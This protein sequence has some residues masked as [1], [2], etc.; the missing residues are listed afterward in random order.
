MAQKNIMSNLLK[1]KFILGFM[2]V[3]F[4]LVGVAFTATSAKAECSLGSTTLKYGQRSEAVKCLQASLNVSPATG[5]FGKLTLAAVKAFQTNK[6]LTADGL[7]GR[8]TKAV[9]TTGTTPTPVTGYEPAGCTSASGFSPVTGGACHAVGTT[10]TPVSGPLTV[11]LAS[12]NPAAGTIVA[13]QATA[14]LAHFTFSGTGTLSAITL[15]RGGI[16]DQNTLSNLYL[17]DGMARL[18]DGYSFNNSGDLTVSGLNLAIA[19]TKTLS[20]RADVLSGT[21]SYSVS[22]AL[23]SYTVTGGTANAVSL[24]GNEMY[25]ASAPSNLGSAVFTTT[26][27]VSGTPQVNPGTVGYTVWST[28]MQINNRALL[29]KGANF[30]VIGSA[31]SDALANVKLYQ[32]GIA[33]GGTA[34][35]TT[36]NGSTYLSFDMSA[37]PVTLATGGHTFDVRADIV[38]GSARTVQVSLQQVSDLML[39]D[40]QVGINVAAGVSG[41]S[42]SN[43]TTAA[44]IDIKQG[45][46]STAV[47]PTFQSLTTL[48]GGATNVTI[49]KFK[50]HGYGEDVKINSLSITPNIG[51][52]SV[53]APTENGLQNVTVY[54][55]GSQVGSQTANWASTTG[56]AGS[57]IT[58][59]PG[60]QM[61]VPAGVDSYLEV[62][63]DIRT[64]GGVN[65]TSGSVSATLDAVTGGGEGMISH[66]SVDIA[67]VTGTTLTVQ[68]GLLAIASN[69]GFA[70]S[71]VVSPNTANTKIA[72]F[73]LQN[74][75]SSESIRV[76]NLQV[77]LALTTAGSTNYSN[78]RT[79][80]TSGSGAT[81]VNPAT[82]SAPG[83]STN[84]FQVDFTIAP[85]T[86]KTI[87]VLTDIGST[88]GDATVITKLYVTALGS[89]SNVTLCSPTMTGG[90][91]NGCNVS[92]TPLTGQTITV[93][94]GS[95]GTPSIMT[96]GT[97][98]AQYIASGTTTGVSNVATAQFKLTA[99]NGNATVT[100]LKFTDTVNAGAVTSVSVGSIS[101]PM[102]AGTA[103]LTGLNIP[104]P[105][106]GAGVTIDAKMSYSQMGSTG[107]VTTNTGDITSLMKLS[108]VKYSM[109]G[110]TST[111]CASGCTASTSMPISSAQTMTLVGSKPVITVSQPSGVVLAVGAVE[112]IDVTI[113]ADSA[114]PISITSFPI[115]SSLSAG[116]GSPTFSTGTGNPF[117]V[118][119]SGNA[120]VSVATSSSFTAT[121]GGAATVTFTT[122][123]P[124]SAGQSQTFKVFLPVAALGT[125][126]L[127][128]T[129]MYTHLVASSGFVWTDVA[130]GAAA[131]SGDITA[132]IYNY[133]S[134]TTSSIH[135]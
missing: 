23:S 129:Y 77:L 80:E 53:M 132:N 42:W 17:Y 10:P 46:L 8:G 119:D 50:F 24:K 78:L 125:G 16:S 91:Q 79:S 102:V 126:T 7:V 101:A 25:V 95:F 76:T 66:N 43:A 65:Y 32:D 127:P 115:T 120:L 82:A 26:N 41:V 93:A 61:I 13:G 108:Y 86:T 124:L 88:S 57:A 87:D 83:T 40:P 107:V 71:Q 18:T 45:S 131:S 15:K 48:T 104:V 84:N 98:A 74:Q 116:A 44:S 135:N 94:V 109:G 30:R 103:Y 27:T 110:T 52:T 20:V 9:L 28:S 1:S 69:S 67:A 122:P 36:I 56:T 75:S 100:E 31:P 113:A 106:G 112:A 123:Y 73:V 34:V 118:K 70:A 11:T 60:S 97:T 134:T 121:S 14:D 12:D 63:A 72:S 55:N 130:G 111:L 47:D 64:T 35:N 21:N 2:I 68:T 128:N 59:T 133:P 49:A 117:V 22:V 5:Y 37:A 58:L 85:G 51:A 114:G 54:F 105:Q 38:K 89:T 4:V 29:L 33:I 81:P 62:K 39:N 3:A 6:G 96:S 19:G 90:S 99:S 92:A